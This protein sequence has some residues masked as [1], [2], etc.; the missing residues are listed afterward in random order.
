M[1]AT[2]QKFARLPPRTGIPFEGFEFA[3]IKSRL[4][5]AQQLQSFLNQC[6]SSDSVNVALIR[7]E[8]GEGKTDAYERYLEPK[9]DEAGSFSYLVS[10]STIALHLGKIDQT[11]S[12]AGT[13]AVSFLA[14]VF[15]ALRDEL[16]SRGQDDARVPDY[17]EYSDPLDFVH[18]T[19]KRHFE[20]TDGNLFLFVDEFEEILNHPEAIQ[21]LILSGIKELVNGQLGMVHRGGNFGGRLH[22]I[23]AVTPYAYARMHDD[24]ELLQVFGSFISRPSM[25]DLPQIGRDEAF[26]FLTDLVRYSYNGSLPE[27]MPFQ[28]AGIFNTITVISQRNIRALVQLYVDV[29][30]AAAQ[31]DSVKIVD[32]NRLID[33]LVSKEIAVYGEP[34]P[35]IDGD[36]LARIEEVLRSNRVRGQQCIALF[37]L[38]VGEYKPFSI[39]EI[40]SRLSFSEDDV[41]QVVEIINAELTKLGIPRAIMRLK[42]SKL[43]VSPA[44]IMDEVA[45]GSSDILLVEKSFPV[46][47][48]RD[49]LVHLEFEEKG[50][51]KET[52]YFPYD[53]EDLKDLFDISESDAS[54]LA[55]KLRRHFE[56]SAR[57]RHFIISRQLADQI[58]PSPTWLLINFIAERSKRAELWREAT[59][60]FGARL[61]KLRDLVVEVISHSSLQV[62]IRPAGKGQTIYETVYNSAGG[63]TISIKTHIAVSSSVTKN[64]VKEAISEMR[65]KGANLG[66][67]IHTED[68][69]TSARQEILSNPQLLTLQVKRVTALQLL[70]LG[71]AR[72]R[73]I[74]VKESFLDARL[75]D[76]FHEFDFERL[77]GQWVKRLRENGLLVDGLT[78]R[79]G[80]SDKALADGLAYCINY[81]GESLSSHELFERITK[82][83]S[84]TIYRENTLFAPVDIESVEELQRYLEDLEDNGFLKRE[85]NKF[86]VLESPVEKRILKMLEEREGHLP[87]DVLRSRFV[88]FSSNDKILE[89]VY[90][91][92]LERKGLVSVER[93]EVTLQD[94]KAMLQSAKEEFQKYDSKI[95]ARKQTQWWTYAI[96]CVSKEREDRIIS[97]E[98]FDE[99]VRRLYDSLLEEEK[100]SSQQFV[101]QRCYMLS[102]LL[103]HFDQTLIRRV[104]DAFSKGQEYIRQADDELEKI[105][106]K[107]SFLLQEYN[108]YCEGRTYDRDNIHDLND[109]KK[110][111]ERMTTIND[112]V[113][114]KET[115]GEELQALRK[116]LKSGEK[117]HFFFGH[118]L[119]KADYFNL[120]VKQLRELYGTFKT[121]ADQLSQ[122]VDRIETKIKNIEDVRNK[123]KGRLATYKIDEKYALTLAF[124]TK[125][126]EL[127]TVPLKAQ[128]SERLSL[129]VLDQFFE[130]AYRAL[131]EYG[132]KIDQTLD[133]LDTILGSQK[134][135]GFSLE[136][137]KRRSTYVTK[138]FDWEDDLTKKASG[139][140][141]L[142]N[143]TTSGYTQESTIYTDT[144]KTI[145]EV[146]Q[147][148]D[149][150][151]KITKW[152]NSVDQK[153]SSV[154]SKLEDLREECK[155]YLNS[156]SSNAIKLVDA[157]TTAGASVA[158]LRQQLENSISDAI[159]TVDLVFDGKS[160]PI[161]WRE[162]QANLLDLREQL[163][164]RSEKILSP[165]EFKVL[166]S[167][168][169]GTGN[170]GWSVME[171]IVRTVS[172]EQKLSEPQVEE[173]IRSL[174]QKKLLREGVSLAV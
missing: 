10:T 90:L 31:D 126:R 63:R 34:R 93:D 129:S 148:L 125:V 134:S 36:L 174:I 104:D 149:C 11:F 116:S 30:A 33:T 172:E 154:R 76:I 159:A 155:N 113:I 53:K 100:T 66:I 118:E 122:A 156:Y 120:K 86:S 139:L 98:D 78:S 119:D 114:S 128:P 39:E 24:R 164:R 60:S 51:F 64:E 8:W 105:L 110:L 171:Q 47:S 82:L 61:L 77:L 3:Q 48:F 151:K 158:D 135:I 42:P 70:V 124:L 115:V 74:E 101:P 131:S 108:R 79:Y 97:I 73:N 106:K 84:F 150:G 27:L 13:T 49:A 133:T 85:G 26:A 35:C 132:S 141:Q 143:E 146:D 163:Y 94:T 57:H 169:S 55:S 25:I 165:L 103:T 96:L 166:Y 121:K 18:E 52:I 56:D 7:A 107:V 152:L 144:I 92:T 95:S 5:V 75:R 117:P 15:A 167:I 65:S 16:R 54:I 58:F 23:I 127:H 161:T 59:K 32:A 4:P 140:V 38:L 109:L 50:V 83:R 137:L 20:N 80:K 99:Y 88:V 136:G 21:R 28:S 44:S 112:S 43:G 41:H 40:R 12:H 142:V 145:G 62:Q 89:Q 6:A 147:L 67:L 46:Q 69:D 68:I 29:M 130:S 153:I 72:E 138:F 123:S 170:G 14:A 162:I 81:L 102:A 91:P 2:T 9:I 111:R 22:L 1:P 173:A 160:S 17:K 37:R 157:L 87:L 45:T 168:V 19:L 71:L